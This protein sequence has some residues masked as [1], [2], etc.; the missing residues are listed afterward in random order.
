MDD[1]EALPPLPPPD[2]TQFLTPVELR[3]AQLFSDSGCEGCHKTT[4]QT[5]GLFFNNGLDLVP[6][7]PGSA[8]GLFR[9]ASLR[10]IAVTAPYMHDGRFATLR[11]VIEHYDHGVVETEHL[12]EGLRELPGGPVRRLNLPEQDKLAL[13]AFF[14]TLT[15]TALNTDPKFADPF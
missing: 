13:E 2:P 1:P 3:G 15:D 8:N 9:A 4:L 10:N 12:S 5:T 14:H 11:Q 6:L 7:D